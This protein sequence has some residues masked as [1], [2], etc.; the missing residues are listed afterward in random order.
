MRRAVMFIF[1]AVAGSV[2][3]FFVGIPLMG[4]FTA[5]VSDIGKSNKNIAASDTTPPAPP[6]FSNFSDFTNQENMDV[7]GVAETGAVVKLTFNGVEQE[8]ITDKDGNFIFNLK[9]IK[10]ENYLSAIAVDGAKNESIA[11][12]EYT[13]TFDNKAPDLTIDS[14]SDGASFF[15]S[16]QRQVTI[17]GTT[18]AGVGVTVNDRIVAV[19]EDGKFQFTT[20]L[21][22][23]SNQFNVKSFDKAGNT[24]EVGISLNFTP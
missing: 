18:E 21:N 4:R 11:T 15:G 17:N 8:T 6:R 24:T 20:T 7:S 5:F 19:E 2:L 9:L 12:R 14:P 16:G 10:G 22:E 23:G 3:L 1:L 13:I